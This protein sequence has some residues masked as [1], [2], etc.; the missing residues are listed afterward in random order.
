VPLNT[1]M[2]RA[3]MTEM[4]VFNRSRDVFLYFNLPYDAEPPEE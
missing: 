3:G 4:D 1:M 2:E